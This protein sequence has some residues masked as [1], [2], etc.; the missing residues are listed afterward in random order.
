MGLQFVIY[1]LST[2]LQMTDMIPGVE[3]PWYQ[4]FY[5]SHKHLKD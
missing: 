1:F 3:L 2:F 5:R 4:V